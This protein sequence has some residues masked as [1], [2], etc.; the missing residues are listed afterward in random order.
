MKIDSLS[1]VIPVFNDEEV[2]EELYRRLKPVIDQLT[3]VY[4][5]IFVDDGST[6]NSYS[7]LLKLYE[8]DINIKIIKLAKNFGQPNSTS[9]GLEAASSEIIILMDSDLQ[10]RPEDIPKLVD[11]LLKNDV[12][13]AI[14][15]WISR[16]DPLFKRVVSMLFNYVLGKITSIKR[17][18]NLGLFRAIRKDIIDEIKKIPEKTGTTIGLLYWSGFKYVTVDLERDSRFAGK[19]GYNLSKMF[20][21][22][23]DL[24]FSY[25]LFPIRIS[26]IIGVVFS[27][28]GF[29]YGGYLIYNKILGDRVIPGWTSIVVLILFISGLQFILIGILGE[30]IGRIYLETKGRPKYVI[31]KFISRS[32]KNGSGRM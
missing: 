8:K 22:A 9:A 21:L 3:D 6:D 32:N 24:I 17:L 13:M 26:S 10:D 29:L 20:K 18:P 28:S 7:N 30:Y 19:S 11:A 16:K 31:E 12:S 5:I 4:E 1:V 14:S 15:R 23:F 25:S 27:I 2:L